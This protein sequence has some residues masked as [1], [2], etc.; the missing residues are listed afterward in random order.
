MIALLTAIQTA[1]T[2]DPDVLRGLIDK[3]GPVA[4]AFVMTLAVVLFFLGR[5]L[6]KQVKRVDP[7]LPL[8]PEDT[9]QAADRQLIQDA[10][11]R[12]ADP[13]GAARD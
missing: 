7:T 3:A 6:L 12:G 4:F 13:D 2:P 11:A 8:G 1:D 5:S 9:Q 10:F